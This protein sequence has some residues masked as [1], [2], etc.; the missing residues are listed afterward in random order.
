MAV[1][2]WDDLG[3]RFYETGVDHGV[4]YVPDD[5][6][7][8]SPGVAW[9]GLTTVTESPSGADAT[10]Q[11]ADNIKYLNLVSAEQFGGTIEALTYPDEFQQFDGLA[12]PT[13]GVAVGQQTRKRFGL[14]YR[15]LKGN[16]LEGNDFGYKLHL[17][18][19]VQAS[20]S[21]KAYGTVNDTPAPIAFSWTV[22]TTPAPVSGLKPT[23]L[24]TIDSSEVDGT[25]LAN[26]QT[27]LYG[28]SGI[29]P[30][31]PTPDAVIAMF[32]GSVTVV[33]P[34]TAPT[35]NSGTHTI[36]VPTQTG[37]TYYVGDTPITAG[38][39]V[40]SSGQHEIITARANNGFII[41]AGN[42]SDWEFTF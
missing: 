35:Y 9:N 38:S 10:A 24:I 14:C 22:T 4:L 25:A 27:V 3:Q 6:G 36:T 37:I 8:Y 33:D 17:M 41:G 11:F 1:L 2:T 29:D 16:D 42:D 40:L 34:L 18:Y 30:L 7:I 21:Q 19:G 13:A 23:S 26:L 31:L 15:T 39:H 20:P 5:G 28:S 32:S 12:I